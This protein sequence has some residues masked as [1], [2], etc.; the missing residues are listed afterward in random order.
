MRD[1]TPSPE[2]YEVKKVHQEVSF[3]DDGEAKYGK[4]RIVNEFLNTN[5]NEYDIAWKL[6]KDNGYCKTGHAH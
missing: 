1:R 5:L 6:L 3:Y 2:L 4:V